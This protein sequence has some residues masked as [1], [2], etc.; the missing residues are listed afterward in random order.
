MATL[1]FSES[2]E[3]CQVKTVNLRKLDSLDLIAVYWMG[4]A[5]AHTILSFNFGGEYPTHHGVAKARG[6][7]SARR[8]ARRAASYPMS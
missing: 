7:R 1:S 3:R 4:D 5:I 8:Q 2:G 6:F